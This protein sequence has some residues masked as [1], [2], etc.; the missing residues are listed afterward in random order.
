VT[1][2]GGA[3][4]GQRRLGRGLEALLGPISK[5]EAQKEGL[6]RDLPLTA[7]EPNPFQPR[8][9]WDDEALAELAASIEASGLL[10]PV[11]VRPHGEGRWQLIAGERRWRAAG[12]L[13]WTRIPAVVKEADDRTLL[14]LA[15]IENLQRDQLTPMDEAR[16]YHRLQEQFG[17]PQAEVA[18]LVGKSR[19][20]VANTLR[21]LKL[22]GK[23]QGMLEDGTLSAGHGRALL[24]LEDD[25]ALVKMATAAVEHGWSVREL[26]DRVAR[27]GR[28]KGP[29]PAPRSPLTA[30]SAEARRIEDVLR[31]RLATDVR[32]TAKRKGRGTLAISYYSHDDLARLLELI[33]GRPFDG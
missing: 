8:Q 5:E 7:V 21:L 6:L 3:G 24:A 10:Q 4:G 18:R 28:R 13:G 12:K 17:L 1:A 9:R 2:A 30:Q 20:L 15:L 14:T 31:K 16:G 29:L 26:E 19:P 33:L 25:K 22:P 32:L 11:V 23:V 27:G